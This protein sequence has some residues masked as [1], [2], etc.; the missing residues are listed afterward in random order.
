MQGVP[1]GQGNELCK[2]ERKSDWLQARMS[3]QEPAMKIDKLESVITTAFPKLGAG[4]RMRKQ[5]PG[6]AV[7]SPPFMLVFLKLSWS[8]G[9]IPEFCS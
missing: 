7:R 9:S 3:K 6:G 2:K 5:E 1:S 4:V 8:T